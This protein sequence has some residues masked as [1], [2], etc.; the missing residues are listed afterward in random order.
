MSRARQVGV[1]FSFVPDF[2]S[3]LFITGAFKK[4]RIVGKWTDPSVSALSAL[5]VNGD[6]LVTGL[7]CCASYLSICIVKK[8]VIGPII[9]W[10]TDT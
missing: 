8:R 1:W 10:T 9:F 7:R 3:I 6:S 5:K 4:K 2:L